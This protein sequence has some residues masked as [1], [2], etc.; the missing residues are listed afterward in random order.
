VLLGHLAV[1][2]FCDPNLLRFRLLCCIPLLSALPA[3]I[4]A[5][6]ERGRIGWDWREEGHT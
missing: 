3:D 1:R 5:R 6:G 2:S 4:V